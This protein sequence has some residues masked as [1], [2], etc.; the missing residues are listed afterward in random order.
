M[1]GKFEEVLEQ[2]LQLF[3]DLVKLESELED[4]VVLCVQAIL[5]G[6]KIIFC[7]NGGSAADAQHLAAELV[8][9]FILERSALPGLALTTDTS[10]LT[11]IS[12]DY[13]FE[14]VYARQIE[15]NGKKGDVLIALSTSGN[16]KN[17]LNAIYAAKKQDIEIVFLGGGS[18]GAVRELVNKSIIVPCSETARI[19]EAHIFL[20]HFLCQRIEEQLS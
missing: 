3:K 9:R 5:N 14:Q 1:M 16:S 20:G 17:I 8:G 11:S 2:H 19:Q 6:N 7:G 10:I 4:I 12:N 13:G 15:A 18:G